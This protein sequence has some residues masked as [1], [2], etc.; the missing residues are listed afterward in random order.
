MKENI[1]KF[2]NYMSQVKIE[3][4]K[5]IKEIKRDILQAEDED[6]F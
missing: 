6:V 5:L 2:D 4:S 1:I 3:K